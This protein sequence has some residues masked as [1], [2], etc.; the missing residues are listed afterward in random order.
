M[1]RWGRIAVDTGV[2]GE[3]E[4]AV[5]IQAK[6]DLEKLQWLHPSEEHWQPIFQSKSDAF[7]LVGYSAGRSVEPFDV[8]D[9]VPDVETISSAARTH[10]EHPYDAVAFTDASPYPDPSIAY[11]DLY[12]EPTPLRVAATMIGASA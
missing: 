11:A 12:T 2:V 9:T 3:Y 4:S 7:F 1:S 10:A 6:G 8:Y 5:G